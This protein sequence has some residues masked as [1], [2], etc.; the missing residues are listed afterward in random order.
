MQGFEVNLLGYDA[1]V[2]LWNAIMEAG[3][4]FN[5]RPIAPGA[6]ARRI[7]AGIFR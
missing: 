5:I 2:D 1:G 6:E 7:E 4:E 3:E